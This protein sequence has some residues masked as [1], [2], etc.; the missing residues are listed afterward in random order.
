MADPVIPLASGAELLK[1][2]LSSVVNRLLLAAIVLLVGFIAGR[3]AGKFVE[4]VV[5]AMELNR[6]VHAATRVTLEI[7]EI[8]GRIVSYGI[9]FLVVVAALDVLGVGSIFFTLI[10]AGIIIALIISFVLAIRDMIPNLLAGWHI[11][12]RKLVKKGDTIK[13]DTAEGKVVK[14]EMMETLLVTSKGDDL[15][16]PNAT[17]I[18]NE[19][20]RKRR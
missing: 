14:V 4:H 18:K 3:L 15:F 6:A 13:V 2:A 11:K 10:A 1:Q 8:L 12:R 9:Y 5:R 7:D 17:L 19:L 20:V 16:I